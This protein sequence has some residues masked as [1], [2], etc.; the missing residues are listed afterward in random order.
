MDVTYIVD[1]FYAYTIIHA[2]YLQKT[3]VGLLRRRMED[4]VAA[5]QAALE[6]VENDSLLSPAFSSRCMLSSQSSTKRV[7]NS[8]YFRAGTLSP[9]SRTPRN[10]R[11]KNGSVPVVVS[12]Y[13]L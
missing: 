1:Q 7:W 12:S 10:A 13:I 3:T 6:A 11:K 8:N 9:P 4:E 2:H 5:T